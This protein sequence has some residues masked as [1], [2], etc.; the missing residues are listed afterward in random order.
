MCL[1]VIFCISLPRS[2]SPCCLNQIR[3]PPKRS[4]TS[5]THLAR[6]SCF[7][8]PKLAS[9]RCESH[10]LYLRL[11]ELSVR[12]LRAVLQSVCNSCYSL[13]LQCLKPS[14]RCASYRGCCLTAIPLSLQIHHPPFLLGYVPRKMTPQIS[15]LWALCL[16]WVWPI[17]TQESGKVWVISLYL[18]L[19]I[20]SSSIHCTEHAL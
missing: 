5:C 9:L 4:R 7:C 10:L 18:L 17:R 13:Q 1:L 14:K 6:L 12:S 11:L 8:V 15:W 16:L 3:S 20:F 19:S 2:S